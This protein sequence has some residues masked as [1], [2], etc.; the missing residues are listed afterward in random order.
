MTGVAL[1]EF[2]GAAGIRYRYTADGYADDCSHLGHLQGIIIDPHCHGVVTDACIGN[3]HS[4]TGCIDLDAVRGVEIPLVEEDA[5]IVCGGRCIERDA[6]IA[7]HSIIFGLSVRTAMRGVRRIS[8]HHR[9]RCRD[10][11]HLQCVIID[12]QRHCIVAGNRV[13]HFRRHPG[14]I[15]LKTVGSVQIPLILLDT[16][17]I[18][19]SRGIQVQRPGAT[20]R[21]VFADGIGPTVLCIRRYGTGYGYRCGDRILLPGMVG[22]S[23]GDVIDTHGIV[24]VDRRDIR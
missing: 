22:Y 14:R 17:I 5:G 12:T 24:G 10:L 11:G 16:H 3:V 9:H 21:S 20:K 13:C 6:P 8:H 15:H 19:R 1:I 18:R 2:I 23:E 4:L 7:A